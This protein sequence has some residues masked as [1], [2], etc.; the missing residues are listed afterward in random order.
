MRSIHAG[1]ISAH[2]KDFAD[3]YRALLGL[4]ASDE[5][6]FVETKG[7]TAHTFV[8]LFQAVNQKLNLM[9]GGLPGDIDFVRWRT[10][11]YDVGAAVYLA[12]TVKICKKGLDVKSCVAWQAVFENN[13]GLVTT[14]TKV[15]VQTS[16]TIGVGNV[17][18]GDLAYDPEVFAAICILKN[19]NIISQAV[20]FS[21]ITKDRLP[22]YSRLTN[23]VIM[24][25]DA[26]SVVV[27]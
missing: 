8:R 17:S 27:L 21:N 13:I 26:N 18:V 3:I 12:N 10:R 19:K 9:G 6:L 24:T 22:D 15:G 25:K 7:C 2:A 11:L 23:I 5:I 4:I 20:T 16:P 14:P 1:N